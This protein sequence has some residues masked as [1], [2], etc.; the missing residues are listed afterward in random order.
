MAPCIAAAAMLACTTSFRKD[1]DARTDAPVDTPVD[2]TGDTPVDAPA[3]TPV[4]SPS[5][6]GPG[7]PDCPPGHLCETPEGVC[8]TDE[9]A[10]GTCVRIPTGG[11]EEIWAP[12]CGCDG[13]THDNSCFRR[14]SGADLLHVGECDTGGCGPGLPDCP[15]G[16]MCE[17][18]PHMCVHLG[19]M[20]GECVPIAHG[21]TDDAPE[22]GCDGTTYA[23]RCDRMD[24]HMALDH[25][26]PCGGPCATDG[27]CGDGAFCDMIGCDG[28]MLICV[29]VPD[30]CPDID[31]PVCSCDGRNFA[32][33]CLRRRGHASFGYLGHC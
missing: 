29:P 12:E 16:H 6:C 18:P 25:P 3:D 28:S 14:Q 8:N 9:G 24:A 22:C 15:T 7:L 23:N 4:D 26:G 27:D 17:V 33:D 30:T 10:V 31:L 32:N 20:T 1:D 19:E 11:C 21:C 5:G 2:P 13:L